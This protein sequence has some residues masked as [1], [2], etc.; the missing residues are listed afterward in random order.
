MAAFDGV[1]ELR[2]FYTTTA[3]PGGAIEHVH[4]MD[5]NVN[6]EPLPGTPFEAIE[7]ELKDGS[8]AILATKVSEYV[9][10][11]DGQFAITTDFSRAELW[12][13]PEGTYDGQFISVYTLGVQ[14]DSGSGT[15]AAHQNTW[16]FRSRDGGTMR[17]QLMETV[18]NTNLKQSYPTGSSL[19]NDVFE[20]VTGSGSFFL[21]RDN[22]VPLAPLNY[23][24]G[25]NERLFRKRFRNT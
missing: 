13:I 16:T 5:V 15:I 2:I 4:T 3:T 6:S 1:W 21:A 11:I 23:S 7:V 19:V 17:V 25:Q 22:S 8:S 24:G 18:D 14:G 10:L 9:E 20:Y 12:A